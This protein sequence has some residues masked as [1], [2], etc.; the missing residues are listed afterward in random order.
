[1]RNRILLSGLSTL[2]I[3]SLGLV[4]CGDDDPAPG[5]DHDDDAGVTPDSGDPVDPGNDDAG[6][7][8]DSGETPDPNA[9]RHE[10]QLRLGN[11]INPYGLLFGSDGKLYV[12]GATNVTTSA[13]GVTPVVTDR[14]LAVWRFNADNTPD[15]T[16]GTDGVVTGDYAGDETSY[17]IV[18]PSPG[19]FVVHF[20]TGTHSGTSKTGKVFLTQ[21]KATGGVYAFDAAPFEVKFGWEG[22]GDWSVAAPAGYT[23]PSF[24]SWGIALDKST[25]GTPKVVVFG[26][27]T[28]APAAIVGAATPRFDD[29]RWIARV[30]IGATTFAY[31]TTFN[32][33]SFSADADGAGLGDGARRGLVDPD[34]KVVSVGYTNFGTGANNHVVL[35]RVKN[36]GTADETF[37]FG[38]T[39]TGQTKFNPYLAS[40]GAA[41][42]Y[43]AVRQASGRYVTTGYGV[44]NTP[45]TTKEN[46][47]VSFGVLNDNL[48]PTFGTTGATSVQSEDDPG[49]GVGVRPFREN[50]RDVVLL[51]DGRTVHVGC[52]DDS[53]AAFVMTANGAPDTSSLENSKIV[54]R[55]AQ[56]FF[57]AA[58]SPDGKRIAATATS[59]GTG[60]ATGALLVTLKVGN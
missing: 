12:A 54:Y 32:G 43:A 22:E 39:S 9:V 37:G 24:G 13:P 40:G 26:F 48:D 60:T 29:D 44:S 18:E 53:A 11:A 34:G 33:G 51:P 41:E 14:R 3:G 6:T 49:A 36:D 15:T 57:A 47:L 19:E 46:D 20:V 4:A 45:S 5:H 35:I 27:G 30:T 31:D 38:T 56:P 42:A 1:M 8:P 2:L 58:V 55:W 16:F 23:G 7:T 10:A 59:V 50:G 52:Y 28:P 25:T 21:L 17:G